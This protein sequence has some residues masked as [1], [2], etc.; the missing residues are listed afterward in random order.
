MEIYK[1][2]VLQEI[3]FELFKDIEKDDLE[4]IYRGDFTPKLVADILQLARANLEKTPDTNKVA[5]KIYFIMGEGLQ[6]ITRHGEDTEKKAPEEQSLFVIHKKNYKYYITTGNTIAHS[7]VSPLKNKL[8]QINSLDH[9]E[10][11][12]YHRLAWKTGQFSEKGGAGLGL[13]EMAKKSN[14][15]LAYDFIDVNDNYAYFYLST[16]VPTITKTDDNMNSGDNTHQYS[17]E[18][19]KSLH[20]FLNTQNV[21]LF[22]KGAFDQDNLLNLLSI[23][24]GQMKE[25]TISVKVFNIM[26]ELLQNI[27]KHADNPEAV[28]GWKPGI[29]FISENENE[30]LLTAGNYI[31]N[32]RV[33][34][35][36][37]KIDLVNGMT[38]QELIA[39]YNKVL[40]NFEEDSSTKTGLGIIDIRKK[41]GNKLRYDLQQ[42][43]ENFSFF[44][45]QS[46]IIKK[47]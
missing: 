36:Q 13:I 30:L 44:T 47:K 9:D 8:E 21:I 43:N 10:L 38:H 17:I 18:H 32:E 14:N 40:L 39:H 45:V 35:L 37:G 33:G 15:K 5:K 4:Y 20:D 19:I 23:V 16:E 31:H 28:S 1:D 3:A 7:E 2:V 6:N 29:F 22:F 11:R 12:K 42:M 41:S 27:V 34:E 24:E 26:V 46:S 25:S